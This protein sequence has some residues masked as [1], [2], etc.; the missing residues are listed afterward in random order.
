MEDYQD[1][2]IY[3]L[4]FFIHFPCYLMAYQAVNLKVQL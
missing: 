4:V 2:K 3:S 1:Y